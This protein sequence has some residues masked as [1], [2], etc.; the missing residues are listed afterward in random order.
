MLKCVFSILLPLVIVLQ[1]LAASADP[2]P[3]HQIDSEHLQSVH[4][5]Q[6]HDDLQPQASDNLHDTADCHHCGHCSGSH[7]T[8]G[9]MPAP[10]FANDHVDF[11][12][13]DWRHRAVGEVIYPT[14][15]PPIV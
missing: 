10:C 5:H 3:A 13:P 1:S 2:T 8:W 7:L 4:S 15:R 6:Q 9:S 14:F 11:A 12:L